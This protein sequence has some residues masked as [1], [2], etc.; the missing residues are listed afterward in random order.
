MPRAPGPSEMAAPLL[1]TGG[2]VASTQHASSHKCCSKVRLRTAAVSAGFVAAHVAREVLLRAQVHALEQVAV[3]SEIAVGALQQV[4]LPALRL[5]LVAPL[6]AMVKR[7]ERT[8]A[9]PTDY[10]ARVPVFAALLLAAMD[11]LTTTGWS[12]AAGHVVQAR[13][14]SSAVASSWLGLPA[15]L[16]L[17]TLLLG[18][19]FSVKHWASLPL[20][21]TGVLLGVLGAGDLSGSSSVAGTFGMLGL[22]ITMAAL[23]FALTA[24]LREGLLQWRGQTGGTVPLLVPPSL[25]SVARFICSLVLWEA[26]F[27]LLL[28]ALVAVPVI[29]AS[30]HRNLRALPHHLANTTLCL[31][32]GAWADRFSSGDGDVTNCR[33]QPLLLAL[34]A[35]S[36]TASRLG[37]FALIACGSSAAMALVAMLIWPLSRLL[38]SVPFLTLAR[39][40]ESLVWW[41]HHEGSGC[42]PQGLILVSSL[43]ILLL[44]IGL[45]SYASY[46]TPTSKIQRTAVGG[47]SESDG[48]GGGNNPRPHARATQHLSVVENGSGGE[49]AI[50]DWQGIVHDVVG[51]T[52]AGLML[53]F[54]EVV[55]LFGLAIALLASLVDLMSHGIYCLVAGAD[56][57]GVGWH[58]DVAGVTFALSSAP[59]LAL[60]VCC[61]AHC[62]GIRLSSC[63]RRIRGSNSGANAAAVITQV[64]PG[65]ERVVL[66]VYDWQGATV[67]MVSLFNRW[68]GSLGLYHSGLEVGGQEYAFGMNDTP[69]A[70]GVF[71]LPPMEAASYF[72][73]RHT[74]AV[75]LGVVKLEGG[76]LPPSILRE[77][78]R[79]WL[80]PSYQLL[81]RNCNHFCDALCGRL[82]A[83]IMRARP[84]WVNRIARIG[85][86]LI[87]V[88]AALQAWV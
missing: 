58:P 57:C 33:W 3:G 13:S 80:G 52:R 20:A 35:F 24:V 83:P 86:K 77:L 34:L 29:Y 15:V 61:C 23:P 28:S 87:A 36:E 2:E 69:G 27:A 47:G 45:Y 32:G 82:G 19:S 70:T 16:A 6:L 7:C 66:H 17:G 67:P 26:V 11:M 41:C 5:L 10:R 37:T 54:G 12:A 74:A 4:F 40:P 42:V 63:A 38:L 31:M 62:C 78:E 75:E 73:H 59:L 51:L 14:A 60:L 8:N 65:H 1:G 84:P 48:G 25:L 49:E 85:S 46:R 76:R 21:A 50:E 44:S 22:A 9:P 68:F 81:T 55:L 79:E 18:R 30:E 88:A 64:P 71:S 43:V 39:V 72:G 56:L 53:L